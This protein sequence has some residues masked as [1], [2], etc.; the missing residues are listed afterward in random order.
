L[1]CELLLI[2]FELLNG[3]IQD[4][5]GKWIIEQ[6]LPYGVQISRITLIGDFL[7][8][9]SSCIRESIQRKPQY[10]FTSGG[11]GPTFDDMT[12]EG[13]AKGLHPPQPLEANQAALDMVIK[14]YLERFS[15]KSFD[16]IITPARKKMANLPK[17]GIPLS[18][19][20]GTAP[21]VVI[22]PNLTNDFTKIICLPGVPIELKAIFQD[23]VLPEI[24]SMVKDEHFYQGGFRFYD[25]G[26]SKFTE[27][28]YEIKDRYPAIWIKTHPK[29]KE[30]M[31]V[32]LHLTAYSKDP[33]VLKQMIEVYQ[34]LKNHVL[35]SKGVIIDETPPKSA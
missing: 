19:R 29:T 9:I 27:K 14:K 20:E 17:G 26:E 4:T 3:K 25:I 23:H 7:E 34:L 2:G 16:E 32:E 10:V 28:I 33:N 12:L 35:Q 8:D 5:N 11:L 31:E 24:K 22:P 21:G 6:L 1:N 13:V 15:N 30:R 18:N